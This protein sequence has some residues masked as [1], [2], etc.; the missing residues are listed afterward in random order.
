MKAFMSYRAGRDAG[1][2]LDAVFKPDGKLYVVADFFSGTLRETEVV[3][4]VRKVGIKR[5]HVDSEIRYRR[6]ASP[7]RKRYD[8]DV[9]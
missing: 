4:A 5:F 1:G 6:E 7:R 8:A 9:Q 3:E 2:A